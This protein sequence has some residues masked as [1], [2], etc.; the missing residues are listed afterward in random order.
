VDKIAEEVEMI[1][2]RALNNYLDPPILDHDLI[3]LDR[4]FSGRKAGAV[5]NVEAPAVEVAFDDA[6]VEARIG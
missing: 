6:A 2:H 1:S 3:A 4:A 5:A